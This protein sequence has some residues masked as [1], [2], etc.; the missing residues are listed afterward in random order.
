MADENGLSAFA[1]AFFG[2]ACN[3]VVDRIVA[4]GGAYARRMGVS[5]PVRSMSCLLLLEQKPRPVT[6]LASALGMTHAGAIKAS[7]ALIEA[8]LVRRGSDPAD[9]RRK[10]LA[11]TAEGH[12]AARETRG[13]IEPV[14]LA[15]ADLFEEIGTD[16]L[17]AIEALDAALDRKDFDQRLTE[18]AARIG[19]KRT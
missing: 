6:D 4:E 15:Y 11:L 8:G 13:F 3:R 14:R 1:P 10:P 7:G 9:R 17:A 16:V 5:A 2:L 19:K 18:A 12:A